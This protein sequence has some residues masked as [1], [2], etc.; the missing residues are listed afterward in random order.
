ME[1]RGLGEWEVRGDWRLETGFHFRTGVTCGA[2][3]V[4]EQRRTEPSEFIRCVPS[5]GKGPPTTD[6]LV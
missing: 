1:V 3:F 2:W 4:G 6:E 5:T